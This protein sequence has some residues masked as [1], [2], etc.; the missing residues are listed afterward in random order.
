MNMPQDLKP[1]IA[2]ILCVSFSLN[3]VIASAP[4]IKTRNPPLASVGGDSP[5]GRVWGL[6]L[7]FFTSDPFSICTEISFSL[8]SHRHI[9][10]TQTTK[11][12]TQKQPYSWGICLIFHTT[13]CPISQLMLLIE[14]DVSCAYNIYINF[15]ELWSF[16][17]ASLSSVCV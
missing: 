7:I 15:W 8:L 11:E 2:S 13:K 17:S 10:S 3:S 16:T 5:C 12:K 4:G 6:S 9:H 1:V 14:V